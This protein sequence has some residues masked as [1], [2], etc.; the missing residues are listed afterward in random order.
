MKKPG[1][2]G[3]GLQEADFQEDEAL[4]D[5]LNLPDT[6]DDDDDTDSDDEGRTVRAPSPRHRACARAFAAS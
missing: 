1:G 3:R 4:Y 6:V 2:W 5:D